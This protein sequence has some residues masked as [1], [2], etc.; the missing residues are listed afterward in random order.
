M[1]YQ[2]ARDAEVRARAPQPTLFADP[3]GGDSVTAPHEYA[4]L[5]NLFVGRHLEPVLGRIRPVAVAD[6]RFCYHHEEEFAFV[7]RGTVE[8]R[9]RTPE[10]ERVEEL[11]RG[12]CVYFRSD[13]PHAF[14]SLETVV[15]ESLHV[16]CSPSVSTESGVDWTLSRAIAYDGHSGSTDLQRLVGQKLRLLREVHGWSIGRVAR[17][18]GLSV[19]HVAGIERGD[20]DV[21]LEAML[22]LAR[23]FGKPLRELIGLAVAKKPYSFVQRSKEIPAIPSRRR[24]T[25]VERPHAAASKTCQPLVS[26]FP[27]QE[28]YPYFVRLLN[29]DVE[30]LNLHEHHG[31][32]FI[33]VLEGDLD[34]TTYSEGHEVHDVLRPGDACYLDSTVPHL[35]RS[36]TRNPFSETSAEVIDLFWCPLGEAYLFER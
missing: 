32:E 17:S 11:S 31:Q 12:D 34:L 23:A 5:A 33:Y 1:P 28:M 8:F 14:R 4:P 16:F 10:G 6:L 13:L 9:I 7:L 22:N 25:P 26:G 15:S 18:A 2:I 30:T 21:P 35:I 3:S 27:A 20:R 29:V 24:R 36:R 19:R